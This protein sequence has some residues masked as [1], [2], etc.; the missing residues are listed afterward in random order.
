MN[1]SPRLNTIA[2]M[3]MGDLV[4]DIGTDHGYLPIYLLK[5]NMVKYALLTDINE[6]P[7]EKARGNVLRHM[8]EDRLGNIEFILGDG[9]FPL[10]KSHFFARV[11][12]RKTQVVISGM[13]PKLIG[14]IL[15]RG[16]KILTGREEIILSPMTKPHELIEMLYRG[17]YTIIDH[18]LCR[19]EKRFYN[20]MK[21]KKTEI[22]TVC[23]LSDIYVGN[24]LLKKRD[25]LLKEYLVKRAAHLG[26]IIEDRKKSRR[27]FDDDP[28]VPYDIIC[29]ILRRYDFNEQR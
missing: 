29:G 19:E 7:L 10:G 24:L 23:D 28:R 4:C 21:V 17:G 6:G 22:P 2:K 27:S 15:L 1:L 5:K 9:L 25:P 14:E 3:I 18:V 20:I 8:G 11:E 26:K 13:G 16:E 12:G